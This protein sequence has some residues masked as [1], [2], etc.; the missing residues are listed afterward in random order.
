MNADIAAPSHGLEPPAESYEERSFG[1][2]IYLMTDAIIFALLFATYIV[3]APNIADGPAPK[4]LFDIWHTAGETALLLLSSITFGFATV[5]MFA[6]K[7]AGVVLW[8]AVS[9]VLGAGFVAMELVE[10]TGMIANGLGPDRSGS[11]SAFFALVGTHGLHVST[12]LLWI[13]VFGI[14][15]VVK[16]LTTPV[17]SR[18]FRLG[19]FWHFLD[20]VWIGI[21]SIVYLPGIM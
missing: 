8:L 16:G 9:F 6:N 20:I 18:V 17:T 12:G 1:F 10:F 19:L 4:T 13:A 7:R 14:Q 5:A 15:V 3:M 21:F 11:A 2:W